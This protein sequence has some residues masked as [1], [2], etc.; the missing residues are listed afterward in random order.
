[1]VYKRKSELL[2]RCKDVRSFDDQ[3]YVI[4][5]QLPDVKSFDKKFQDL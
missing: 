5:E 2:V 3:Y 1:M 4:F